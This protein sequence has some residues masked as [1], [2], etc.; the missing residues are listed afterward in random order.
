[1]LRLKVKNIT[2]HISTFTIFAIC[3]G[4]Q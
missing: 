2:I 1:M 3:W 4:G